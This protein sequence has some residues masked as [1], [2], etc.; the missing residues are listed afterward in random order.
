M[1]SFSCTVQSSTVEYSVDETLFSFAAHK[2]TI[3]FLTHC[4]MHGVLEAIHYAVP[5][6]GIPVFIDQVKQQF[7]C[8]F[9][10]NFK[11]LHPS[12]KRTI[13]N[14]GIRFLEAL[15][16]GKQLMEKDNYTDNMY[17]LEEYLLK[18][19]SHDTYSSIFNTY[20]SLLL[21]DSKSRFLVPVSFPR[22]YI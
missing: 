15:G 16:L 11:K 13:S 21:R 14:V 2:N 19:L 20:L 9:C 6:V 10:V 5:M 22:I 7:K 3:L 1:E 12:K 4:G 17:I 8:I 18:N